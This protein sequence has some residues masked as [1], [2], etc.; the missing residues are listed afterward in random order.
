MIYVCPDCDRA[1][2]A[3]LQPDGGWKCASCGRHYNKPKPRD[4]MPTDD[5][6]S[7]MERRAAEYTAPHYVFDPANFRWDLHHTLAFA[8]ICVAEAEQRA[9]E[10]EAQVRAETVEQC[11]K[12]AVAEQSRRLISYDRAR[13][14]GFRYAEDHHQSAADTAGAIAAAIR[15][16]SFD[17]DESEAS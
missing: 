11:A 13:S 4:A 1:V 9:S 3:H 16:R 15:A 8:A 12:V 17:T 10:R 6:M 5:A 7:E 2:Q 14:N